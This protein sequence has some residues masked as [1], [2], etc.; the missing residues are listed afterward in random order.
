M[1]VSRS[2]AERPWSRDTQLMGFHI[3]GELES[4]AV[5][6]NSPFALLAGMMLDQH[7]R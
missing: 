5:L 1:A 4:D 3:T 2:D 6:D 7:I